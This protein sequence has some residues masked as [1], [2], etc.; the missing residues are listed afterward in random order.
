MFV[1]EITLFWRLSRLK[2]TDVSPLIDILSEAVFLSYL[3]RT[4]RDIRILLKVTFKP[5]KVPD[6]LNSLYFL[7]LLD[8]HHKPDE[9]DDSYVINVRL[10]HPLSNFNART[11]GTSAV[12]GCRIDGEGMTYI[13]QGG[14]IRLRLVA[15]MAKLLAKPDRISARTLDFK[16]KSTSGLLNNKQLKIAK[17]AYDRGWYDIKSK[18]RL[19]DMANEINISRATLAEHL[20][21]I[22]SIVMDDLLGSFSNIRVKPEEYE[23]FKEMVV[24]DSEFSGYS[25]DDQFKILLQNIHQNIADEVL[26]EDDND[27]NI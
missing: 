22:E 16:S 15:A 8:V 24:E 17:Y 27:E 5:G 2:D 20:S 23:I 19:S 4:P 12:P 9:N 25:D 14:N 18:V 7:E 26:E 10:S 13:I 21:R 11:G 6:D 3:K 1:R